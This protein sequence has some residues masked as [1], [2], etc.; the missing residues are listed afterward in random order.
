LAILCKQAFAMADVGQ[1]QWLFWPVAALLNAT[2][3]LHFQRVPSGEWWD[4]GHGLVI[5]KACAGGNFLVASWLGYVWAGRDQL[6]GF[7]L[8][9][10]AAMAA[11]LTTVGANALRILLIALA[12][13]DIAR[14]TGLE[15]GEAH[16]LIGVCV[17]FICLGV[18]MG[19]G[20]AWPAAAAVYLGV[21]LVLPCMRAWALGLEFP[22]ASHVAWTA[23]I[24][25]VILAA[26]AI[27]RRV[28]RKWRGSGVR[29]VQ[30]PAM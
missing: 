12:Q 18:Q 14:L 13:E 20:R 30:A 1:L 19:G 9:V 21:T 22:N 16:R 7:R 6:F 3:S 8:L 5:V 11:W 26:S 23:A 28:L 25:L 10:R 27:T 2:G 15:E 4:A 24:P 17:Y 29:R